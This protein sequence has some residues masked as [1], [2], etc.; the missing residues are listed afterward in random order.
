[1]RSYWSPEGRLANSRVGWQFQWIDSLWHDGKISWSFVI[2]VI[3]TATHRVGWE[4][5][6]NL[7]RGAGIYARLD[8][9]EMLDNTHS[10]LPRWS[11]TQD[12]SGWRIGRLKMQ[13]MWFLP[14]LGMSQPGSG[15]RIITSRTKSRLL[16][17]PRWSVT[18]GQSGWRIGRLKA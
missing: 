6:G 7:H 18:Q 17:S 3:S 15:W 12:Q 8:T 13:S 4:D 10:F 11:V 16:F 5:H 1:M 14:R 2:L 9:L